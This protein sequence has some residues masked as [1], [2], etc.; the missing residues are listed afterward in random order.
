MKYFKQK[1]LL[2]VLLLS[3]C[4]Q[5]DRNNTSIT[6]SKPIEIIDNQTL[7]QD[8][9]DSI[10]QQD[11]NKK[12]SIDK[13]IALFK[14]GNIDKISEIISCP[15]QRQYPIPSIKDKVELKQRFSEVFDKI[16][17]DKIANSK[18]EQW[19]EVGWRGSMLDDGIVWIDSEGEKISAVNYQ[20]D[21]EK[22]L[23]EDLIA[24]EKEVLHL[25]LKNFENPVYKIKTKNYLIR[26][27]EL[28]NHKYRY[29][30]WK[31]SN[32]E[33]SKPSIILSNGVLEYQGSGGNLEITFTSGD[34]VY[35]INRN[36]IGEENMP[37]ITL[38]VE[39]D[40]QIILTED[41]VLT[42]EY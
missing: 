24:K 19:K 41:G 37:D 33:S 30:S 35:K 4:N 25:S 1:H 38:E 5:T 15:L 16:L 31:I 9:S 42:S 10:E 12:G 18:I 27:D 36:I 8:D 29:A 23:R 32:E 39:K 11:S 3:G 21:F 28:S 6:E 40:G 20:S 22:K 2:L 14:T 17:I 34:V 26:I 13:T 7:K